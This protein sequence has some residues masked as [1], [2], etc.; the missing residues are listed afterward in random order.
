VTDTPPNQDIQSYAGGTEAATLAGWCS[1]F[2][3]G[4]GPA[5]SALSDLQSCPGFQDNMFNTMSYLPDQCSM[6]FSPGQ[7][8]RLQWAIAAYR[9][10]LMAAHASEQ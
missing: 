6:I 4:K 5:S 8:E 10:K 1:D 2:R 7:V 9:P 3:N